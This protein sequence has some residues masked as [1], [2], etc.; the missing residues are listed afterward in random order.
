PGRAVVGGD[1]MRWCRASDATTTHG[2]LS[3]SLKQAVRMGMAIRRRALRLGG[4]AGLV[5]GMAGP[6]LCW[7]TE[8]GLGRQITGTNVQPNAGIV[9]PQPIT[10]INLSQ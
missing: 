2:P 6:A 10:V 3:A 7:A 9:A 4:K 8:G 1:A 5:L